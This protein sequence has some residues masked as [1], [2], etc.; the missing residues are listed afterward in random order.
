MTAVVGVPRR[1]SRPSRDDVRRRLLDAALAV[2]AARGYDRTSLDQ[3]A[4]AA[5]FTKGAVYSNF[6]TKDELFLALLD[7]ELRARVAAVRRALST[8][9][10]PRDVGARLAAA[11]VEDPTDVM[12]DSDFWCRAVRDP[13]VRA[14]YAAHRQSLRDL[15]AAAVTDLLPSG[16]AADLDPRQVAGAALALAAGVAAD[17]L[18]DPDALPEN[19]VG[20][21][22]A[23]V[24]PAV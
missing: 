19:L 15:V 16:T 7:R 21:L 11:L 10:G 1:Q 6:A 23:R 5:G 22:L 14:Q 2:V 8:A 9:E 17:R 4:A 18:V 20:E 3:V 13:A 24:L 12:V